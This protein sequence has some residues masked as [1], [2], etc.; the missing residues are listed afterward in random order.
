MKNFLKGLSAAIG[1]V[2]GS[3]ALS[4][5]L[6]QQPVVVQT[7]TTA[8]GSGGVQPSYQTL[9]GCNRSVVYDAST[10]GSTKL[11]TGATGKSIYV[12]GFHMF[13]G[14]TV[15]VKL[16][17]GT[18]TNC[19]T[20]TAGLTPA[21]QFTAQTGIVDS[22]PLWRGILAPAAKDLCINAS[23]G[24]AMQALVFYNQF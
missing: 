22:S 5:A 2:L 21:Y 15:N 8:G 16:V 13:S 7:P 10:S 3:M 4:A 19:G 14:G 23:G 17:Y 9:P 20:G 6:A 1:I 11:I 18:G 24:V 12:C